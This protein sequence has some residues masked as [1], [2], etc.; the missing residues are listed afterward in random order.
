MIS[1]SKIPETVSKHVKLGSKILL[2]LPE[3][4]K[5]RAVEIVDSLKARGFAAVLSNDP[6]YGACDLRDNEALL[7]GCDII[8]HVGHKRF[9]KE[10]KSRIPVIYIP[11]EIEATYDKKE[12]AKIKELRIGIISTVNYANL[13]ELVAK[14]LKAMDKTPVIGGTILGCNFQAAK[15]IDNRIDCFLFIGT[16]RFHPS[17]LKMIFPVYILDLE[18]NQVV[19]LERKEQEKWQRIKHIKLEKFREARTIGILVSSKQGQ[20]MPDFES[21]KRRVESLG[22]KPYIIVM[23]YITNESLMGIRVDFFINTACPRIAEDNFS[24]PV[25]N[26]SEFMEFYG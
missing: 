8:V 22:K 11:L 6:C 2:Q 12:L 14:D 23:D 10:F 1:I 15:E 17:G 16:G 7:M 3:G 26:A 21:L 13:M 4:L 18:K 5:I 25:L 19:L 20:F 24:K 9:Y